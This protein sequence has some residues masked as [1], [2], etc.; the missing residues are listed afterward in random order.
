MWG[1][2]GAAGATVSLITGGLL[3]RYA[4]WDYIFFLN[5]PIGIATLALAPRV[6]T[7]SRADQARRRYDPLGA[8]IA[9]GG[10]MLLVYAIS[11]APQDGWSSP[12]TIGTLATA[13]VLL[14]AFVVVEARAEAPLLPLRMLRNRAVAS[15]N[16]AGLL[17]GGSFFAF[18][19]IGTLSMQQMLGYSALQTGLAWPATSLNSVALAGLSQVLV[20]R[21]GAGPVMAAGMAMIAGGTLWATQ[22]PVR[23]TFWAD[24]AGGLIVAGAGTAFAFISVAGLTG[25]GERDAGVASG[26]LNTSQQ[27]G[28]AVTSSVATSHAGTLL[29]SGHAPAAALTGGFQWA[30]WACTAIA[31]VGVPVGV[32]AGWRRT[33]RAEPVLELAD[34]R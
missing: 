27:I 8:L 33:T 7:E 34:I 15:A 28:G 11:T 2:L 29:A 31:A 9:T 21:I 3:T 12:N 32:L 13:G 24:L 5:V 10:L 20:T 22:V 18:I 23:D 17:L 14:V 1:G 25:V 19:F 30:L 26:L 6:V 4:G 16:L